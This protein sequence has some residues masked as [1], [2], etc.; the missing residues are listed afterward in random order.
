MRGGGEIWVVVK[1]VA[2]TLFP[3]DRIRFPGKY[4]AASTFARA[5]SNY[6]D[7]RF[8]LGYRMKPKCTRSSLLSL[9]A[10]ESEVDGNLETAVVFFLSRNRVEWQLKYTGTRKMM[11]WAHT[12]KYD[13]KKMYFSPHPRLFAAAIWPINRPANRVSARYIMKG[14]FPLKHFGK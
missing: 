2:G 10:L 8:M 4:Y 12:K 1:P 11:E 9:S 3:I 5:D 6:W 7:F 13:T 14:S